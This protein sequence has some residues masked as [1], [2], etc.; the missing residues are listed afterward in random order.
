MIKKIVL[1]SFASVL[2]LSQVANAEIKLGDKG[3][4]GTISFNAGYNSNYIW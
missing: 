3:S 1:S 2:L 4:L